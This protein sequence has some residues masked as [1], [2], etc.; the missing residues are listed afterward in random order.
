MHFTYKEE[1]KCIVSAVATALQIYMCNCGMSRWFYTSTVA[2]L[3]LSWAPVKEHL[4]K[5]LFE[6]VIRQQDCMAVCVYECV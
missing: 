1:N 2:C 4:L 5:W 3:S 6:V